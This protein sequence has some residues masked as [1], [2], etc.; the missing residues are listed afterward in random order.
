[1]ASVRNVMHGFLNWTPQLLSWEENAAH[2]QPTAQDE[3]ENEEKKK[4]I[5]LQKEEE[6]EEEEK[7][8]QNVNMV[9]LT[10]RTNER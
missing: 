8:F 5:G 10:E 4:K 2:P 9:G 7:S 1:M 3:E 6:E